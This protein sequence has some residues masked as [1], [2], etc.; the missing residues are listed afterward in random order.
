MRLTSFTAF[1]LC[2]CQTAS[3][4][5]VLPEDFGRRHFFFPDTRVAVQCRCDVKPQ[6]SWSLESADR[7]LMAGIA[8]ARDGGATVEFKTPPLRDGV[9]LELKLRINNRTEPFILVSRA[10]FADR[11]KWLERLNI[12]LIDGP[13]RTV[14]EIFESEGIPFQAHADESTRNSLILVTTGRLSE[15]HRQ[16]AMQGNHVA[17]FAPQ[18]AEFELQQTD[19]SRTESFSMSNRPESLFPGKSAGNDGKFIQN[20]RHEIAGLWPPAAQRLHIGVADGRAVI[21]TAP[22]DDSR[23]G[24]LYADFQ[25]AENR[26]LVVCPPLFAHW[27]TSPAARLFL[28]MIFEELERGK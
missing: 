17:V 13:E 24:W 22:A 21:Q 14:T 9:S 25:F 3:A 6:V 19:H 28:N 27:E 2:L 8:K 12:I 7:K 5:D 11:K 16:W 1:V 18:E 15:E 26:L 4:A 23:I 20:I 10:V